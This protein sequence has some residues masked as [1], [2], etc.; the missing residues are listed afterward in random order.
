MYL[1]VVLENSGIP[2]SYCRGLQANDNN[3]TELNVIYLCV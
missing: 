1:E 3:I 2:S